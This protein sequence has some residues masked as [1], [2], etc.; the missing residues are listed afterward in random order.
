MPH[1]DIHGSKPARGS[2]W[3]FAACHVLHRLL[4]PR[5]PPNALIALEINP[6]CTG[7]IHT[8]SGASNPAAQQANPCYS[9]MQHTPAITTDMCRD[10]SERRH[11]FCG[12]IVLSLPEQRPVKPQPWQRP[13]THQNLIHPDKEHSAR[14]REHLNTGTK[15]AATPIRERGQHDG[16]NSDFTATIPWHGASPH[17][18]AKAIPWHPDPLR[19]RPHPSDPGIMETTGFEPVTPCLQS[20]CS[21]S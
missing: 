13:E 18:S 9:H 16:P 20:R 10:A 4:V 7:A 2:P 21:P 11:H 12:A 14:N 5:H 8:L 19:L 1:S 17:T 6:P 15:A 3:L